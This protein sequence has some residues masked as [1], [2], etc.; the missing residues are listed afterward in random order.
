MKKALTKG[1]KRDFDLA[2]NGMAKIPGFNQDAY[3]SKEGDKIITLKCVDIYKHLEPEYS[4]LETNIVKGTSLNNAG[5]RLVA[6]DGKTCLLHRLVAAAWI[7]CTDNS[8]KWINHIDGDKENNTVENL[9][10]VTRSEN[11]QK[12]FATGLI[13]AKNHKYLGRYSH[14]S[15]TYFAPDGTKTQMSY[16][17]YME[18]IRPDLMK[19]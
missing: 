6:V 2:I 11:M 5:Y 4:W 3:I 7:P 16:D 17:E 13:K 1:T 9:E 10:W 18:T 19:G 8:R 15:H 14:K 12:A